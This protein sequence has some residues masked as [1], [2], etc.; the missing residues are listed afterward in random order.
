MA[1]RRALL[2]LTHSLLEVLQE[3]EQQNQLRAAA[4]AQGWGPM[5]V[6]PHMAMQ[7]QPRPIPM[8]R[9]LRMIGGPADMTMAPPG[10]LTAPMMATGACP[11]MAPMMAPGPCPAMAPMPVRPA[12]VTPIVEEPEEVPSRLAPPRPGPAAASG[13]VTAQPNVSNMVVG[14]TPKAA[15]AAAAAADATGSGEEMEDVEVEAEPKAAMRRPVSPQGP[16]P[17]PVVVARYATKSSPPTPAASDSSRTETAMPK[18]S[19]APDPRRG[20]PGGDS[21]SGS[22]LTNH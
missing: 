19:I 13:S 17:G 14:I 16:P 9:P 2:H 20:R 11:A 8:Q 12:T 5:M 22:S 6:S 18:R 4:A 10:V 3:D 1:D 15:A 21:P 7:Q